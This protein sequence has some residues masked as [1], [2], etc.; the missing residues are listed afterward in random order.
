MVGLE[1]G[2]A[3]IRA[4]VDELFD[5]GAPVIA[6]DAQPKNARAI[7]VHIKRGCEDFGPTQERVGYD[8]VHAGQR[9]RGY[10]LPVG[11]GGWLALGKSSS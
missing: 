5:A 4:R 9:L 7:V 11:K 3:I 1:H 6:T 8:L 10:Q 2:T